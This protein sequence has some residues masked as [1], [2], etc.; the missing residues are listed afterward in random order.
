MQQ[1]GHGNVEVTMDTKHGKRTIILPENICQVQNGKCGLQSKNPYLVHI[2][3]IIGLLK[4]SP[5]DAASKAKL[6]Q[7]IVKLV[8]HRYKKQQVL[9][10]QEIKSLAQA[11]RVGESVIR[12]IQDVIVRD[13][14]E[15]GDAPSFV[16]PRLSYPHIKPRSNMNDELYD[17]NKRMGISDL[18]M[19]VELL[20]KSKS[21]YLDLDV[22]ILP[23]PRLGQFMQPDR[24][25]AINPHYNAPP[26]IPRMID[27]RSQNQ[28]TLNR[29]QARRAGSMPRQPRTMEDRAF[30][31]QQEIDRLRAKQAGQASRPPPRQSSAS[32][33]DG[34][35][36]DAAMSFFNR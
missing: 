23:K 1:C 18:D 17:L 21:N 27:A 32:P 19:D 31:L 28:Q 12:D 15:K 33:F 16:P 2:A 20:P 5:M 24:P 29:L 14:I 6:A 7:Y 36:W 4:Y 10:P 3:W 11:A 26:L 22:D 30:K 9:S 34:L 8:M 25:P 13:E 35:G